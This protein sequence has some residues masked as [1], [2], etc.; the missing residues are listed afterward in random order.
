MKVAI[1]G[2]GSWATGLAR[3]LNDNG[4]EVLLYGVDDR[5]IEDI[6]IRHC[7]YKY[8]KNVKLEKEIRATK[9]LEETIEGADYI[10]IT[11]PTK[12]VRDVLTNV[13]PLL[14]KKVTIV[15]AS[16]G[17]DLTTNMSMSDTIRSVFTE[18]EIY[19]VAS[20]IGPSHAE[21]VVLR[22]LTAVCA[23][24]RDIEVAKRVQRLFANDYLRVY[25]TTDEVGAEMGVAYKNVIA[26]ASGILSG[27]GYGDNARA[28]LIT[29]GLYEMTRYGTLKGGELQT[30]FGLTGVGDLIVTC[31]SEHS[32]N[33]Q[34][35]KEIGMSNEAQ[36][37]MVGHITTVEG[38]RTSKVIHDEI[39]EN[40]PGF[41]APILEAV[42]SVLYE[43][44]SPKDKVTEL[45]N[46]ELKSEN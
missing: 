22:M 42:Y 33:F 3:V 35:G 32:R 30:F 44:A 46:R 8:F 37:F 41:E 23:V 34:A 21:E 12:F 11:I 27:L 36:D 31:S 16:K 5:E 20:I 1:L 15:N 18:D 26:V 6:N 25:T 24:S 28:A 29:R 17:F 2:T 43:N 45:M 38:V 14:K 9:N 10:L 19:P 40:Y 4:N 7:N 39:K 13:K